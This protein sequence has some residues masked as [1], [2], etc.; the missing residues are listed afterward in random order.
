[1]RNRLGLRLRLDRS[2]VVVGV[3]VL[4]G[5]SGY[6]RNRWDDARAPFTFAVENSFGAK[7]QAGPIGAGLFLSFGSAGLRGG[8]LTH[9]GSDRDYSRLND[10]FE[11]VWAGPIGW[12]SWSPADAESWARGKRWRSGQSSRWWECVGSARFECQ[13]SLY[14][15]WFTNVEAAVGLFGGLRLGFNVGEFAD[16]LLGFVGVDI[17]GDDL[18][19][20]TSGVLVRIVVQPD[21]EVR[22]LDVRLNGESPERF[23]EGWLVFDRPNDLPLELSLRLRTGRWVDRGLVQS[24]KFFLQGQPETVEVRVSREG[25]RVARAM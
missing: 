17:Y 12:D 19:S 13:R 2:L 22:D 25:I 16:F 3:L 1:M 18:G 6:W 14:A 20:G 9:S 24:S 10:G 7:A 4:A 23:A 21:V 11:D 5:C 15:P 8:A